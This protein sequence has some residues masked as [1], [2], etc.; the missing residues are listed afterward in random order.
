MN[1]SDKSGILAYQAYRTNSNNK[2]AEGRRKSSDQCKLKQPRYEQIEAN[3]QMINF[4][5]VSITN[6]RLTEKLIIEYT[7]GTLIQGNGFDI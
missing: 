2:K 3:K 4:N 1:Y 5:Q 6:A 7:T